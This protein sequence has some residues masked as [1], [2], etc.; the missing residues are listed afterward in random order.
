MLSVF[1]LCLTPA[2]YDYTLD[3][4]NLLESENYVDFDTCDSRGRSALLVA[5]CSPSHA[6]EAVPHLIRLGA[7]GSRIFDNGQTYLTTAV[8]WTNNIIILE[9]LYDNGCAAHLNRQ[10]KWGWTP[11]HYYIFS[12]TGWRC[13]TRSSKV[14][15]LLDERSEPLD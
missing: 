2:S 15:F 1:N 13:N 9:Y 4:I 7:N 3:Y 12:E 10:D 5:L 8:E 14:K 11:L 6:L